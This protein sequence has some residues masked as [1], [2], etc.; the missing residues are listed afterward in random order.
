MQGNDG[1]VFVSSS[2]VKLFKQKVEELESQ[3]KLANFRAFPKLDEYLKCCRWES[4]APSLEKEMVHVVVNHLKILLKNLQHYFPE[5]EWQ[6]LEE[7]LWV[8][9]PF[10]DV[11]ISDTNLRHDL[12]RLQSDLEQRA[13]FIRGQYAEFWVRA[14]SSENYEGLAMKALSF[15]V[16]M[17]NTYLSEKGF[18][19]LVDIKTKK[20][21]CLNTESLDALMRGA[22]ECTIEPNFDAIAANIQQ[23]VSH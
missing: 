22:L 20:R 17:P 1:D 23:N 18:S 10:G 11:T 2:K 6:E 21:N 19:T 8:L 14:F 5:S 7:N 3:A 9:N 13:A 4:E 16:R 15:L 12:L